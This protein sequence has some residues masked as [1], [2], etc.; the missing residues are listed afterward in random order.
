L[1]C[2]QTRRYVHLVN[3]RALLQTDTQEQTSPVLVEPSLLPRTT[4]APSNAEGD[5]LC[6]W[7]HN[8]VAMDADRFQFDGRDE[9]TFTNPEGIGFQ[10][11]TFSKTLG[12]RN[13]GKPTL[14]DTWF[15]NHAWSYCQCEGCG[16]HLG[17]YYNG[18]REFAGLIKPRIIRALLI[19]N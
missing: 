11:I 9:F 18:P 5:W 4:S 7:C 15:A 8:R 16:Q 12:C 3:S 10:I 13:A 1:T 14:Q 2:S 6:A 19:R 17:W